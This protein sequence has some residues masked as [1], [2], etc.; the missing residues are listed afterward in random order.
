VG[1]ADNGVRVTAEFGPALPVNA[2]E[3]IDQVVALVAGKVVSAEWGRNFL[4]DRLGYQFS[5]NEAAAIAA[6]SSAQ[7]DATGARLDAAVND[8][9]PADGSAPAA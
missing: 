3:I 5:A 7:L 6:E 8:G 4:T 1:Y 9:T 2:K